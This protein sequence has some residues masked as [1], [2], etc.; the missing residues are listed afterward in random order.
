MFTA[1][2]LQAH[3][4]SGDLTIAS[5]TRCRAQHLVITFSVRLNSDRLSALA[6]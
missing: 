1:D 5:G 2:N 6:A 3:I 4:V